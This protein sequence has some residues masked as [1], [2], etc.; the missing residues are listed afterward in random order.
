MSLYLIDGFGIIFKNYYAMM[1]SPLTNDDGENI[2][3][4]LGFIKQVQQVLRHAEREKK[5]GE[6]LH[7]AMIC[8]SKGPTFRHEIYAEYKANRSGPPDDLKI[9]LGY[10]N[11]LLNKWGIPTYSKSGYEADDLIAAFAKRASSSAQDCYIVTGDKD[12]YQLI[13]EYV[14]ILKLDKN[15]AEKHR[16]DYVA[17]KW[18]IAPEQIRDYL[19]LVGDSADNVPGV[20]GIG[21]K[22]AVKLL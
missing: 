19:A 9:Q 8:D 3:A 2:S 16:K 22:S 17:E 13:D 21:P 10:L 5:E 1:R 18:G 4:L 20:K 12:L 7:V 11:E 14:C 6:A 15:G